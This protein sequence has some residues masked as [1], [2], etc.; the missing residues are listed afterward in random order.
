[1][2]HASG[3]I[4]VFGAPYS[5][6]MNPVEFMFGIWKRMVNEII[7]TQKLTKD[8]TKAVLTESFYTFPSS[9]ILNLVSHVF[10]QVYDRAFNREDISRT[11]S[12][13]TSTKQVA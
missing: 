5:P 6:E 1:M 11:W 10:S 3:H 13:L 12:H 4:L 2:I 9:S 7:G 8:N